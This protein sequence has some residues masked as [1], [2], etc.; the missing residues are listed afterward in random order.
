MHNIQASVILAKN[1][2]G[3]NISTIIKTLPRK[4]GNE[5]WM[6]L[7]VKTTLKSNDEIHIGFD[8]VKLDQ[9]DR[10]A[11]ELGEFVIGKTDNKDK[12]EQISQEY[13]NDTPGV[14]TVNKGK[15]LLN[16]KDRYVISQNFPPLPLLPAGD[17]EFVVY[18]KE[19][20]EN[21]IL[22]TFPFK[23]K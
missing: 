23:V 22:D 10:F 7:T 12:K 15:S 4:E 14:F 16:Y 6:Y 1:I 11:I 13:A 21:S 3:N 9:D 17:Y 5:I 19:N 8:I 2:E 20:N 18:E